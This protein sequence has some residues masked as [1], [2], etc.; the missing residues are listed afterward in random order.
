VRR[1][2]LLFIL[3]L[4]FTTGR[5]AAQVNASFTSSAQFGCP[6]LVVTFNDQSTGGVTSWHWEF[7][8]GNTSNQQDPVEN[9]TNP[10]VYNVLEIVSNGTTTDSQTMQIRV[11]Q[12]PT[13]SFTSY[14]NVGCANPCHM[15]NFINLTIPGAS[16]VTQYAWDF[17]DGSLA[18]SGVN[19][20]HCY[21][22]TGTFSVILVARDSNGCQTSKTLSDYVVIANPPSATVTASPTQTCNTSLLVNF[23]G[24]GSS[25][26]GPITYAWYF[27]NGG[28][29]A[30]QDPSETF[31]TGIYNPI[32]VVTDSLGCQDT[33]RTHVAVTDVH[34]AFVSS[35]TN[36]CTGIAVQ[37]TDN[38]NFANS[39]LWNFGDNTTSTLQNPSH[40]YNA[41]GNYTVSLTVAYG[42][43]KDSVTHVNFI[44]VTPP[45][46]FSITAN[47]TSACT[48]PF[49]V[50]FSNTAA[51]ATGYVWNFGDS[52]AASNLSSPTHTYTASGDYTVSLG[53]TNSAGCTNTQTLTN[54]I[55]IGGSHAS[56]SVDSFHGCAPLTDG[57][58][59][60]STSASPIVGY[61]WFF[62]DG[63]GS[64]NADPTYTYNNTGSYLPYLVVTNSAGCKD[65][66]YAS[67]SIIVGNTL[68]PSFIAAP[69]V[70]CIDQ[71]VSFTN[72]T[73]GGNGTT[74][75]IWNFG[76]GQTSN[77]LNPTHTYSDTGTYNITLTVVNQGCSK[78]TERLKYILIVVPKAQFVFNFNCNTPTAVTFRDTSEGAQSWL[79]EF[80][81]GTTSNVQDPPVH[82][83]ATQGT[84]TVTLIVKN[85]LTGCV[86]SMK[87]TIP[88]G[89][90][91]VA[92]ISDVI[93]GCRN[94]TVH[95]RDTSVFASSWLWK[96]GDGGVS[97]VKDPV[98][99][100]SD[101]GKYTVVL[102][103]NPGAT[104][105]AKDSIHDYITVYGI[106]GDPIANPPVGCNPLTVAFTD[107]SRSYLGNIISW[108]WRFG[109]GNDSSSL[110]SPTYTYNAQGSFT[111]KLTVTD[112]NGC[113]GT[114][115]KSITT[116]DVIAY[117]TSDTIVCPGELAHF[118]NLSQ[119]AG[120]YRWEFGDNTSAF[121]TNATHAYANSGNYTVTLIAVNA[122]YGCRD[123]FS[124]PYVVHVDTPQISFVPSSVFSICPPFPVQFT[125]TSNRSGLKWMWYFGDGDTSS[126]PNPFHIYI[127]P[128]Y[129][130]VLLV[131]TDS[132]GCRG[133]SDSVN[134]IQ[135]KGPIGQFQETPTVGCVPL[136]VQFSGNTQSTATS[137]FVS[138][139]GYSLNDTIDNTYTYVVSGRYYPTYVLTDS[140]GCRVTYP[141]APITVGAYPYQNLPPDT[142]V[143]QGNYVQFNLPAGDTI[144]TSESFTWTSN[145]SET[146]LTCDTCQSP[147]SE[148]RDTITYY[149]SSTSIYTSN[150]STAS[151]IAKDTF[152][153]NVNALP[154]IF[155]GLNF[156]VCPNDTIQMHAGP[157]VTQAT[158]SPDLF[159]SDTGIADPMVW[160]ADTIVYRVTGVNDAGCS[161]SRVVTVWPITKVVAD[162]AVHDTSVC[163]G[164]RVPIDVTV[165]QASVKD[166]SF[167]WS[168]DKYLNNPTLQDAIATLPPGAYNYTVVVSSSTCIADTGTMH[169][170]VSSA[171]DL[172]A[173]DNQTV[174]V[175]TTVQL[176]AASH[177]NVTYTWIPA[178]DSFSCTDCL[179][180]FIDVHQ[181]QTVH[182]IAENEYGC[183]TEDSVK[184]SVLECDSKAIFVPNT[185]TPNGDGMN[186][187]L[188][189][190]GGGVRGIDY[191]RV[192]DRWGDLVFET[193]DITE[194]WDG[195]V[196]GRPGDIATYVYVLE[197]VCSSG[198]I[199]KMSGNVTLVR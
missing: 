59:N 56:F 54:Y 118:T 37:F 85:N 111:A 179:R 108:K 68:F 99:T 24:S 70:Q 6:P 184:L 107:S 142:T 178:I 144:Q 67:D 175:G 2:Y 84:Y 96:F 183:A 109:V 44:N 21:T 187:K 160:P 123:T 50:N 172:E 171:P 165:T 157:N 173:G 155:P 191:F 93:S 7:D 72:N 182:V 143:C 117:F 188:F 62:G 31:Q 128:G 1:N 114:F 104:C 133:S 78:D 39:W 10:G 130:N 43:C 82:N 147:I 9:F 89:T 47:A 16:P 145:L 195:T 41:T 22:Q 32:L 153:M 46:N 197:A 121:D 92:F 69:V 161:I 103:I 87:Q 163:M 61:Q 52:S 156:R 55:T 106:I 18:V 102:V 63:G 193:H 45:I 19:V 75:Y 48:A 60:T 151:C 29:S 81:D 53:V 135:I 26:N 189:V 149:I 86:D 152:V 194:G 122:T 17:G 64:T 38:S 190:R 71:V 167:L 159:I 196:K 120:S 15:V 51:G 73:Q 79:W 169:I 42:P 134:L 129:Y 170:L 166:T 148:S 154:E 185:F 176:Y 76:D 90:P 100:Y 101:T 112:N 150:T 12:P 3:L 98:H 23:T 49:T 33:A 113:S 28:T 162:I 192:F 11:Y 74:H 158:W 124:S 20:S 91:H 177:Q 186:D 127:Y 57:F 125:N 174:A 141:T 14:N 77:L 34:A 95:F 30:Q 138:G 126:S 94:L 36:A 137:I 181:T 65:T 35:T 40:V 80:G 8:N 115:N 5:L 146:Y 164:S 25:P 97:S 136:T 119:D 132:S 4:L 116:K 139:D 105:S 199:I 27:G 198:S 13:D 66:A 131:G 88:I 83:Y 58:T 180:P 140:F 168:P 110:E